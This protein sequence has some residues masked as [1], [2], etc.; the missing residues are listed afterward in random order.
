[1]SELTPKQRRFV[2]EY[3]IDLNG[4]AAA[5]RAGYAKSGASV[6]GARLLAN[7]KVNRLIDEKRA[8]RSAKTGIDAA[9]LLKRLAE[10]AEADVAD[11]YDDDGNLLPVKQWP[12]I[13]RQ[14]LVAGMDVE[15]LFE[16]SGADRE[17]VG[18]II[19]VKLSDRVKRLELIGKHIGVQAF[20]EV[21]EHKGL[22]GLADRLERASRRI[23]GDE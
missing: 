11:L 14:G 8:E 6:E 22:D 16:G 18:N 5:I 12:K 4:T 13:W 3:L 10:E 21:V 19:K 17:H 15:A 9:W 1:M 20:K 23:E 2:D 7:A